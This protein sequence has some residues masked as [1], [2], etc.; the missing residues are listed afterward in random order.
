[1][2]LRL[3]EDINKPKIQETVYK[4]RRISPRTLAILIIA[5]LLIAAGVGFS[6]MPPAKRIQLESMT[7]GWFQGLLGM[8]FHPSDQPPAKTTPAPTPSG[9]TTITTKPLRSQSV[10]PATKAEPVA[11]EASGSDTDDETDGGHTSRPRDAMAAKTGDVL[12]NSKPVNGVSIQIDGRTDPGW[13]TPF[14]VKGLNPGS[15]EFVFS[16][17]GYST[18][19]RSVDVKAGNNSYTVEMA[20]SGATLVVTSNPKG[21]SIELDGSNTGQLTPHTFPVTP[22]PHIVTLT[23]RDFEAVPLTT[24]VQ[25][26]KTTMVNGLMPPVNTPDHDGIGHKMKNFFGGATSIPAGKGLLHLTTNPSGAT[27][28]INGKTAGSKTPSHGLLPTGDYQVSL[29]LSGYKDEARTIHLDE[30]QENDVSIDLRKK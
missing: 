22:G 5:V 6:T 12:V 27:V 17:A 9:S 24:N 8:F 30:G 28:I 10:A 21:A 15:H 16:L 7:Q 23:M 4:R 2:P 20:S 3:K 19:T 26:G 25:A 13:H 1:M 29:H 18:E 11:S 14:L